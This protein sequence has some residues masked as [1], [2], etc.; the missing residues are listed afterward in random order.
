MKIAGEMTEKYLQ[1]LVV[2]LAT[3]LG[4]LVYH[5]FD[6]RRSNPGFPDL[7]MTRK[8]ELLA[9]ELK[10]KH[11]KLT[12]AQKKWLLQLEQVRGCWTYVWKPED[13]FNGNIEEALR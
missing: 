11:G 12:D 8:G 5:T 3:R 10:S 4:W 1:K 6:S 13:W 2:E 7:M 9:V